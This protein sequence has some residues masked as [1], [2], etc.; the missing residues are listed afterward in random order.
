MQ[1]CQVLLLFAFK[2]C[3]YRSW[4]IVWDVLH[5]CRIL[6]NKISIFLLNLI[7]CFIIFFSERFPAI[8][9][10]C[11]W[12]WEIYPIAVC[13]VNWSFKLVQSDTLNAFFRNFWNFWWFEF[14]YRNWRNSLNIL[15]L[16]WRW[17]GNYLLFW[18][19]SRL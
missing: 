6:I 14:R 7:D 12:L 2:D 13:F 15:L 11:F 17:W 19:F 3:T 5:K 16:Y 8:F 4:Y 1:A 10:N 18:T 9:E